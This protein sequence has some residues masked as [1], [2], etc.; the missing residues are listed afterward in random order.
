MVSLQ[1]EEQSQ[2]HLT[3]HAE[4]PLEKYVCFVSP[5]FHKWN[6]TAEIRKII[7]GHLICVPYL[8]HIIQVS[9]CKTCTPTPLS[10]LTTFEAEHTDLL[11]QITSAFQ[12][13]LPSQVTST[14]PLSYPSPHSPKKIQQ[15]N[16][17]ISCKTPFLYL[18]WLFLYPVKEKK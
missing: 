7:K 6:L 2:A 12:W 18:I 13:V 14:L 9:D 4:D 5:P 1:G 8:L 16:L 3:G 11:H 17:W 10:L 15:G